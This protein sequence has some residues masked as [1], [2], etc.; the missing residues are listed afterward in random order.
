MPFA[1]AASEAW[2]AVG[3]HDGRA[4]ALGSE[5]ADQDGQAFVPCSGWEQAMDLALQVVVAVTRLRRIAI[6]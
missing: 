5:V 6:T 2:K 1:R 4:S 3:N